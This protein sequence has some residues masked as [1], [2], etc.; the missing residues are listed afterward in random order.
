MAETCGESGGTT[1]R[2]T[3]E[4]RG[5]L[6]DGNDT[7]VTSQALARYRLLQ[8]P[9][10]ELLGTANAK[11]TRTSSVTHFKCWSKISVHETISAH[12]D[13]RGEKEFSNFKR[14]SDKGGVEK[15]RK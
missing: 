11:Q 14:C 2:T 1:W 4:P 3:P 12:G 13:Y 9:L 5:F 15:V 7:G 8:K 10:L 6:E